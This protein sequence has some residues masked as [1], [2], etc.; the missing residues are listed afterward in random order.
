MVNWVIVKSVEKDA[1][2]SL[3]EMLTALVVL[4]IVSV[5]ALPNFIRAVDRANLYAATYAIAATMHIQQA[6]AISQ[7]GFQEIRF[8]PFANYY[9][10]Y[11]SGVGFTAV[12]SFPSGIRYEDGYLHLPEPTL[13]YN[14]R[15]DVSES[16][17]I[18]LIDPEGDKLTIVVLLQSGTIRYAQGLS[19]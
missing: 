18:G 12:V 1:G 15:G 3:I 16:G 4:S 11:S 13:R 7:Q 19:G 14:N 10:L 6:R 2:F 9:D 5:I 17:Q 8:A